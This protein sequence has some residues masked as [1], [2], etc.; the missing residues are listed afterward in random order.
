MPAIFH[1]LNAQETLESLG[2]PLDANVTGCGT[3]T[4]P[5]SIKSSSWP[6]AADA[7]SAD[8]EDLLQAHFHPIVIDPT[9]PTSGS[10][11]RLK[12]ISHWFKA[13]R[14]CRKTRLEP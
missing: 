12:R 11:G 14:S 7:E 13:A 9:S 5:T 2:V 6:A 4:S 3:P 8:F 10:P 1:F